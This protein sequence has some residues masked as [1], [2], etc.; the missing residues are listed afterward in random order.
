MPDIP[1][2]CKDLYRGCCAI[3]G[4]QEANRGD[5]LIAKTNHRR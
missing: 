5:D 2:C 1:A 4:E 3:F